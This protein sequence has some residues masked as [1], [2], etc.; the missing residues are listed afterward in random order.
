MEH[1]MMKAGQIEYD[2]PYPQDETTAW[3]TLSGK[4][5]GNIGRLRYNPWDKLLPDGRIYA[6]Y[7]DYN[8]EVREHLY[9]R[10]EGLDGAITWQVMV[11]TADL[12]VAK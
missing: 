6:Y 10:V 1:E 4:P 12:E 7:E 8:D 11:F 9:R 2:G 5:A 3:L